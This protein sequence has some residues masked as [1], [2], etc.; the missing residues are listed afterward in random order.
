[1]KL[2]DDLALSF[3]SI[4]RCNWQLALYAVHLATGNAVACR[5][6]K[7]ATIEKYLRNVAKFCTR[8][9]PRDPRKSEQTQKPLALNIQGVIKEVQRWENV[10]DRR[11]PFTIEML[12]YL[13]YL[14]TSQPHIYGPDS[15]LAVL[16]DYFSMSLYDGFRLSE[17]AQPNDHAELDNPNINRRG[18]PTAFCLDDFRF[19]S[20]DKVAIPL[21][22]VLSLDPTST[23]VGRDFLTYRTQKNGKDG[24]ERQHTRNPS[25]TA[26]CHCTSAITIVQRFV[27]LIGKRSGMPLC[28]YRHHNGKLRYITASIIESTLRL[29]AAHVYKL[30]PL[31]D[32][33]HLRKWSAHSLRVGACVI[34]HGM[35]FT[36]TQIQFLLRWTSNAFYVYLRNIAGLAHKQNLAIE[37]LVDM[38]NFI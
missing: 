16:I 38:P 17:W 37:E 2:E 25:P 6:I 27:R 31:R 36:D 33:E 13:Q 1:M 7:A 21:D 23:I 5:S 34:L 32:S 22:T 19:L 28:V 26:P 18:D 15:F 24:E 35:G 12:R 3:C 8:D 14:Y 4:E 10:P 9:N 11:E 30:D 20:I 29:A